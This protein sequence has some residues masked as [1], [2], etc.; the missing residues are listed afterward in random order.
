VISSILQLRNETFNYNQLP[1]ASNQNIA[2]RPFLLVSKQADA[3]APSVPRISAL[4]ARETNDQYGL[5][6][7][8]NTS[9]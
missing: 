4:N 1:P 5:F 8:P 7:Q 9:V 2:E 6:D 3:Q